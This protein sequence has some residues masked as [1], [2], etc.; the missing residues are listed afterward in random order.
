MSF[1]TTTVI[2]SGRETLDQLRE[3]GV[4]LWLASLAPSAEAGASAL[5]RELE[6][7]VVKIMSSEV[8]SIEPEA[9]VSE[10]VELLVES[11][12]GAIPV[13]RPGT[14]EVVGIISYIDV[15]RGVLELLE[16]S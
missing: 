7:P 16:E 3:R 6:M 2:E 13:V 11:R 12:V 14:R 8:I 4:D 9:S 15:L 10:V 1:S 5:R